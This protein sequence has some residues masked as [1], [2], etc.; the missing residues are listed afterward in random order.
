MLTPQ[1]LF[2]AYKKLPSEENF[3]KLLKALQPII[4]GVC[5]KVLKNETDCQD[6]SQNVLL[7]IIQ[8]IHQLKKVDVILGWV[9]QIA[10]YSSLEYKRA[11][12]KRK[13]LLPLESAEGI[14]A[15][16]ESD[17][18]IHE[19]IHKL[20]PSAQ[21]LV[22]L[23]YFDNLSF[24][25]ICKITGKA[26][27][28]LHAEIK[29][30]LN[31]LQI[32]LK[33]SGYLSLCTAVESMLNEPVQ[34]PFFS[35]ELSKLHQNEI[36]K[37]PFIKTS[38]SLN[39]LM[40]SAAILM[41][42]VAF[43]YKPIARYFDTKNIVFQTQT[44]TAKLNTKAITGNINDLDKS[45]KPI[46]ESDFEP[47]KNSQ[48]PDL[49]NSTNIHTISELDE[50]PSQESNHKS[51]QEAF[52]FVNEKG[53]SLFGGKTFLMQIGKM[54]LTQDSYLEIKKDNSQNTKLYLNSS[55][56]FFN[57]QQNFV[58]EEDKIDT[59]SLNTLSELNRIVLSSFAKLEVKISENDLQNINQSLHSESSVSF[60]YKENLPWWGKT[61]TQFNIYSGIKQNDIFLFLIKDEGNH[62]LMEFSIGKYWSTESKAI[63]FVFGE[64][65]RIEIGKIDLPITQKI[66]IVNENQEALE[67]CIVY[68]DETNDMNNNK[69]EYMC[70]TN[71]HKLLRTDKNGEITISRKGTNF[72]A[73]GS[74][75]Y[76]KD[77][78]HVGQIFYPNFDDLKETTILVLQ[79]SHDIT[80]NINEFNKKIETDIN[81]S[82][83]WV[84]PLESF[85]EVEANR[86]GLNYAKEFITHPSK[87]I[88]QNGTGKISG[89]RPGNYKAKFRS[90]NYMQNEITFRVDKDLDI[91][92]EMT[93]TSINCKGQ[94]TN[95]DGAIMPHF[96]LQLKNNR[97][98][99]EITT[100]SNGKYSFG[101]IHFDE[102]INILIS[103]SEYMS[104]NNLT[105]PIACNNFE[106]DIIVM[107]KPILNLKVVDLDGRPMS[108]YR[109]FCDVYNNE[110]VNVSSFTDYC[111]NHIINKK[112]DTFGNYQ[113]IIKAIG[114]P[115]HNSNHAI[116]FENFKDPITIFIESGFTISGKVI[117]DSGESLADVIVTDENSV[118]PN[119][120]Q[121]IS[122]S[123]KDGYFSIENCLANNVYWVY[124]K[125]YSPHLFIVSQ[126]H[127]KNNPV[128]VLSNKLSVDGK[129]IFKDNSNK[130]DAYVNY[131][132]KAGNKQSFQGYAK[133]DSFGKFKLDGLA[134]GN[135]DIEFY[136]RSNIKPIKKQLNV[137]EVNPSILYIE[138]EEKLIFE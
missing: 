119:S 39:L 51:S 118:R 18:V 50:K 112:I 114:Y 100:D 75:L 113:I 122:K 64:T 24:D 73:F 29:N 32:D 80:F 98:V 123:T 103:D 99:Q 45:M 42:L 67:N 106:F 57:K 15:E 6:V 70:Q 68:F 49:K 94:V 121:V 23:K 20:E 137:Q 13:I 36:S 40:V 91:N 124:K 3:I 132:Y 47:N 130:K 128:I 58:I 125:G 136:F 111:R 61:F 93:A 11:Q 92:V 38:I 83:S 52:Y 14:H 7:K 31:T 46:M 81:Y 77:S 102:K 107:K 105:N 53:A 2:L 65:V 97:F 26:K 85:K 5:L 22:L 108:D 21:R 82:I 135:W 34:K 110:K 48:L 10:F 8:N 129:V 138:A 71:H 55:E 72:F 59:I 120:K 90:N 133:V 63:N 127:K 89:L 134:L 74:G 44:E 95:Y 104:V 43:T 35:A 1:E 25:E 109:F 54:D 96:K 66:K 115:L 86:H 126:S 12:I 30:I 62:Q 19:F 33:K 76:I 69:F 4:Y 9:H 78:N 16:Q 56:Y 87:G 41:V 37:I 28:T 17:L 60:A 79:K 101:G 116:T 84:F 88:F 117:D 27:S 131:I